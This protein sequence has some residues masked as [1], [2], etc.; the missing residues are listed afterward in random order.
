MRNFLQC[1][2]SVGQ[3]ATLIKLRSVVQ[4]HEALESMIE[5]GLQ[6]KTC[7][8]D[9]SVNLKNNRPFYWTCSRR[10]LG[11]GLINQYTQFN[12]TV[13]KRSMIE[14]GLLKQ[15]PLFRIFSVNLKKPIYALV[16]IAAN[17]AALHAVNHHR[18]ESY[19]AHFICS[20]RIMVVPQLDVLMAEVRFFHRTA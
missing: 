3:S 9:F 5:R 14:Q 15:K 16:S 4:F 8:R 18:F 13:S 17:G 7:F 1:F 20:I 12:S 2:S 19:S 10:F 6:N 11:A